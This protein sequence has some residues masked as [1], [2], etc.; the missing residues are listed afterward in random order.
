M[1]PEQKT[2]EIQRD[3]GA[4]A[5]SS[6]RNADWQ[7]TR[8]IIG[9]AAEMILAVIVAVDYAHDG[10]RAEHGLWY[11]LLSIGLGIEFY[12]RVGRRYKYSKDVAESQRKRAGDYA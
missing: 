11:T 1:T 4:L 3:M 9:T 10:I 7:V 8:V 5:E 12:D 2:A 6:H